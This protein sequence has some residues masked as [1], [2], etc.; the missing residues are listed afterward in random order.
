MITLSAFADEIGPELDLQMDTCEANGVHCIDVRGIDGVNVARMTLAQAEAY[1][2]RLAARGF[3]VPCIGSPIG[4]IRIGDDFQAHLER[5]KHCCDVARAFGTRRIRI[6]SFYPPAGGDIRAHRAQ[7]MDQMAAMLQVAEQADAVLFHENE[8]AIYGAT[9]DGVLDL[10]AT[11]SSDRL[12]GIFDPSNYVEEGV[13][14]YDEG[15]REGLAERTHFF[16]VKDK[17]HGQPASVPAGQ[18]EG[19]FREIFADL[20]VR[21]W[22][23]YATLEPHLKAAGQFAGFTGPDLFQKAADGLKAVCDEA[24]IPYQ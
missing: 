22:S 2:R 11:L 6:F 3:T 8:K 13:R 10:F 23:G 17:V 5:L 1:A 20:K 19:Q 15:W 18:G 9:P 14:P 16:H 21:A 24:G 7:V 12:R 4:K